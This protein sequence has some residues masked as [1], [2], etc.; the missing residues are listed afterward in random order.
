MTAVSRFGEKKI[1]SRNKKG[2]K[3][4]LP[5]WEMICVLWLRLSVW[6]RLSHF[7]PL[8]LYHHW[9]N[10]LDNVLLAE[11][12]QVLQSQRDLV[13]GRERHADLDL[14]PWDPNVCATYCWHQIYFD[15]SDPKCL[16]CQVKKIATLTGCGFFRTAV[17][18]S[19]QQ[20]GRVSFRQRKQC[21]GFYW[22]RNP[23]NR[24]APELL[25]I[26]ADLRQECHNKNWKPGP[27]QRN[28]AA[29]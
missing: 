14:G 1:Y 29:G 22:S 7:E 6:Q 17:Q 5:R 28:F 4:Q 27:I 26:N 10:F 20:W 25:A 13:G 8:S 3:R 16:W 9:G 18:Y 21:F 23:T 12:W 11:L 19:F 2:S 24:S 15:W